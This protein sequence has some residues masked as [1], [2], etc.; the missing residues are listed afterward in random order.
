MLICLLMT[1]QQFIN[2]I[3]SE[4]F[5]PVCL[6]QEHGYPPK[7]DRSNVQL[8]GISVNLYHHLC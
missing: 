3:L 5:V 2:I 6:F 4:T 7:Q 8:D 1:Q